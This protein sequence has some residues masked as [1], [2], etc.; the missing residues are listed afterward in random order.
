MRKK[1]KTQLDGFTL[2]II[3]KVYAQLKKI[4]DLQQE[5][6]DLYFGRKRAAEMRQQGQYKMVPSGN[7]AHDHWK[8]NAIEQ[9]LYR[10]E[11]RTGPEREIARDIGIYMSVQFCLNEL[12]PIRGSVARAYHM[13][14]ILIE[15]HHGTTLSLSAIRAAYNNAKRSLESLPRQSYLPLR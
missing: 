5:I 13:T 4:D 15:R 10:D 7:P 12:P 9:L 2:G 8:E 6:E 1:T 11:W 14:K 3:E